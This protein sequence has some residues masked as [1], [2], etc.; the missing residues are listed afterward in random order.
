MLCNAVADDYE[1][2]SQCMQAIRRFYKTEIPEV[3]VLV[4]VRE[5]LG[6]NQL[7]DSRLG[8]AL[9]TMRNPHLAPVVVVPWTDTML[10]TNLKQYDS[11]EHFVGSMKHSHRRDFNTKSRDFLRSGGSILRVNDP[12]ALSAHLG[13]IYELFSYLRD[14]HISSGELDFPVRYTQLFFQSLPTLLPPGCW[15]FLLSMSPNYGVTAFALTVHSRGCLFLKRM[16]VG[17]H[18]NNFEYFNLLYAAVRLAIDL[19]CDQ[20]DLGDGSWDEKRKL[21]AIRRP[22]DLFCDPVYLD[23]ASTRFNGPIIS[24]KEIFSIQT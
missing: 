11:F 14:K 21:G 10:V 3:E 18:A 23:S 1:L 15:T 6:H 2:E 5:R 24:S 13:T 20:L 8:S 9:N 4:F 12:I 22:T 16:G 19:Q 17:E 7:F